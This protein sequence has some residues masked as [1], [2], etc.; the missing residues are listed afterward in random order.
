METEREVRE[1]IEKSREEAQLIVR[2][3]EKRG[4]E[5]VEERRQGAAREAQETIERMKRE[6][7]SERER[8]IEK[9]QGGS[10]AL[11]ETR[12]TEIDRAAGRV[13]AVVLG[14]E[15]DERPA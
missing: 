10:S 14:A 8:Q 5:L 4:R 15:G 6:A 12:R 1:R 9:V 7:E 13:A 3:A 11:I 2:E